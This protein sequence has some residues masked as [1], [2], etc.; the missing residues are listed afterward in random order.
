[1]TR[2]AL[3]TLLGGILLAGCAVRPPTGPT[4]LAVPPEGK[5]LARFQ[6]EE[7]NCR[8][9]AFNQ[10]GITP[11]Q[12]A[13]QSAAGSAVAGT[14]LGVAAGALLGAAAGSPGTGAA[15]GAGTGLL[16]G[17]AVGANNAQLSGYSL[18]ARYDQAY[19]QCLA[20]AGNQVQTAATYA[21]PYYGGFYP[22]YPYYGSYY[23]P[24]YGGFYGPGFGY[25]PG[26]S[27]GLGF[28]IGGYRHFGGPRHFGGFGGGP[29]G[30]FGGGP[31]FNNFRPGP[32][33]R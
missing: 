29:R 16:A 15:L 9:Y 25:R 6:Q 14:A 11:A 22:A 19:T 2:P 12:A 17:S 27:L 28:G 18:Q 5:D 3:A 24:Y 1:M 4:V 30:G 20:S 7:A 23:S 13:N 32:F 8:N 31:S 10:I 21:S 26:L 33:R